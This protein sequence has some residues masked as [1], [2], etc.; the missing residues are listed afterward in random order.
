M[1]DYER[2]LGESQADYEL[3]VLHG[4]RLGA[5]IVPPDPTLP[6]LPEPTKA[7]LVALPAS[8]DLRQWCS[9]IKDQGSLGSCVPNC[10]SSGF[11]WLQKKLQ[12]SVYFAGSMLALYKWA[13]DL[14]GSTGDVGTTDQ[15]MNRV[16]TQT[17]VAHE[18]LWP[19]TIS[20]FDV[21]PPSSVKTDAAKAKATKTNTV[22][23]SVSAIKAALNQPVPVM[24][25]FNVYQGYEDATNYGGHI[26]MPSGTPLG[27][28]CNLLVGYNDASANRDGSSG[29][30]I[31]QNSWGTV[32]GASGFGYMPY[33][34]SNGGYIQTCYTV[35]A[36]SE[37]TPPAPTPTPGSGGT[38]VKYGPI[39]GTGAVH[40]TG[41]V[42]VRE[43]QPGVR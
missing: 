14:D 7:E 1:V 12:P 16:V 8:V 29:A 27:G 34:Y 30:F 42:R 26:A 5:I 35:S 19:Y 32:W 36:E 39:T 17:G 15:T 37:I 22:G 41:T 9:P 10:W 3:R 21:E 28:H 24:F 13:R 23:G 33:G 43:F 20:Q 4:R 11:E 18:S 38:P 31:V 40:I 25:T 6:K 2:R